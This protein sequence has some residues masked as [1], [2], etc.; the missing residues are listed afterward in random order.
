ME[1]T[2]SMQVTALRFT[3]LERTKE[4]TASHLLA[5]SSRDAADELGDPP[6]YKMG[7]TLHRPCLNLGVEAVMVV[8]SC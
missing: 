4:K 1:I 5:A 2:K 6:C 7:D 3:A 8:G